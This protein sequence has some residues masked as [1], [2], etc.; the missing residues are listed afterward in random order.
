MTR[1]KKEYS[2]I[3]KSVIEFSKLKAILKVKLK[4]EL[5][6]L[7]ELKEF[8]ELEELL[9]LFLDKKE[10]INSISSNIKL[11]DNKIKKLVDQGKVIKKIIEESNS[12]IKKLELKQLK[13][14]SIDERSK[15]RFK[16]I[17]NRI[18]E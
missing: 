15:K 1:L 11:Y 7:E 18:I 14:D 12:K 8:G 10:K 17:I 16:N 3:I 13:V 5:E 4:D 9:D 2:I 6:E